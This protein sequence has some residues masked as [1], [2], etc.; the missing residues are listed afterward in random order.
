MS[1]DAALD[2]DRSSLATVGAACGV[3]VVDGNTFES[4]GGGLMDG[5]SVCNYIVPKA[6]ASAELRLARFPALKLTLTR[7]AP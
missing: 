4:D 7:S 3:V 1:S 2:A 6:A 5:K